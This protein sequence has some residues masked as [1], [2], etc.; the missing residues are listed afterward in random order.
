MTLFTC[1]KCLYTTRDRS[2]YKRHVKNKHDKEKKFT[3]R[4]CNIG[5]SLNHNKDRHE[6]SVHLKEKPYK[7]PFTDCNDTF[8]YKWLVDRHL[9]SSKH[10]NRKEYECEYCS[11]KFFMEANKKRHINDVH[12][13]KKLYK[14]NFE[15]CNKSFSQKES[16]NI[17]KKSKKHFGILKYKCGNED[18]GKYFVTKGQLTIHEKT[19]HV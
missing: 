1:K 10:Y 5:F 2:N 12:L 13:K 19:I 9:D 14:C 18:C 16:L 6:R 8:A 4:Y 3:C 15:D 7:C 11:N 17:H